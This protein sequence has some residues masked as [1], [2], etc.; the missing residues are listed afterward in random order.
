MLTDQIFI[1]SPRHAMMMFFSLAIDTYRYRNKKM[2]RKI[3]IRLRIYI[4]LKQRATFV[5]SLKQTYTETLLDATITHTSI[6][7]H[8]HSLTHSHTYNRT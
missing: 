7:T 6:R 8:P 3:K 2:W 1:H 5:T 4:L